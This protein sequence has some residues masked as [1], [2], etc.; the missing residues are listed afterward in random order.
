MAG[1][2][3]L[4]EGIRDCWSR[5]SETFD[6]AFGHR[7]ASGHKAGAVSSCMP[8]CQ[9][10]WAFSGDMHEYKDLKRRKPHCFPQQLNSL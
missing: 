1:N 7:I 5:R 6:L 9:N 4:K 10:R 3:D 2:F 8:S